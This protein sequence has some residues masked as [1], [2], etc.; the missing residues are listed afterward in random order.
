MGSCL[1]REKYVKGSSVKIV[2]R[3]ELE[4]FRDTWGLHHKLEDEQLSYA[5]HIARVRSVG[6]YHGG[7]VLY[8]LEAIPG[9]WHECCLR[10]ISN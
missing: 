2:S 7:D 3:Q 8:E 4:S 10:A 6:F 1:Y 9:I 5:D